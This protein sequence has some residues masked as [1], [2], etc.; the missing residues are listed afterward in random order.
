MVTEETIDDLALR[1]LAFVKG[2]KNPIA[3]QSHADLADDDAMI[4]VSV[5]VLERIKEMAGARR[6]PEN[7]S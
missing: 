7:D 6:S 2:L 1:V 4:A 5:R 3:V